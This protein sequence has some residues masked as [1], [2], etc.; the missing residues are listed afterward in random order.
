MEPEIQFENQT[1][2]AVIFDFGGVI[3]DLDY[4]ATDQRLRR[5]LGEQGQ[6]HYT[7]TYQSKIFDAFETGSVDENTFYEAIENA[8]D[9]K[10]SRQ[11]ID[12]AWCAMLL[13][14][15]PARFHFLK[16][17]ASQ[18]R[19]FLYSNTNSIHKREFD[20]T[21]ERHLGPGGFDKL[22]EKT[23]YSHLFGKRKPHPE[24]YQAVLTDAGLDPQT[25]LFIDDNVANVAG[26]KAAGLVV[27]H[28][29][30]DLLK[31]HKLSRLIRG[32]SL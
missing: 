8:A 29:T 18:C 20:K 30:G 23:Y 15:P 9:K 24:A 10:V 27:H 11:E 4:P 19:I 31:D 6:I 1:I 13:D 21:L 25:T 14:V 16:D 17:V 7:K 5:L 22:F 32:D 12:D 3:L 26:A 28:L 2:K